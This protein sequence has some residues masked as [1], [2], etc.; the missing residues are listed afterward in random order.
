VPDDEHL[1]VT[2]HYY[3]PFEFTHQGAEWIGQEAQKWLGA[4]WEATDAQKAE[5]TAHFDSVAEWAE[6][7]NNVRILLG[8]FGAY[9]K[10]DMPS[11]ARW[12]EFVS[13][14]AERHGFAWGYWE[15]AAGFGIYDPDARVLREELLKALI[16]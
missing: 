7:H 1:I 6:R 15:F 8:E 4:T 12:T 10:A 14:E 13:R 2:F 9:S 3:L 5:I 11:R 16:P